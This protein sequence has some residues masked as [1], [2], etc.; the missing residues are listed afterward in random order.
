[1][2]IMLDTNILFKAYFCNNKFLVDMIP[3]IANKNKIYIDNYCINEF[4]NA[5]IKSKFYKNIFSSLKNNKDKL[6]K[7]NEI[8]I[9]NIKL[10]ERLMFNSGYKITF[11]TTKSFSECGDKNDNA[12]INAC[13][14]NNIDIL[15]SDDKDLLVLNQEE[16]GGTKVIPSFGLK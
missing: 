5:I 13:I 8:Y 12:I 10:I 4:A 11:A 1:M 16:I 3:I 7:I 2:N 15:I 6:E 9:S 14:E